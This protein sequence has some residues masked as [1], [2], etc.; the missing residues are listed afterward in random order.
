[1]F[2]VGDKVFYPM[3]GAG[4]IKAI[5]ERKVQGKSLE[6]CVITIPINN[7]DIM[8]PMQ[9]VAN[10]RM[11]LVEDRDT[12]KNILFDYHNE[13]S[14][15]TLPWKERYKQ[16]MEKLKTGEMLDCT[17]VVR[18]LLSRQKEKALN[19]SEKQML[20]EAHKILVSELSII[21]GISENQA[22]ELLII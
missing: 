20:N 15:C 14:N 2:Q 7:M 16:N 6:Y 9:T 10:S 21:K 19:S 13:E 22:A 4:V 18:D 3:H 11:R 12:T 8:I 1:M 5:E 17:E